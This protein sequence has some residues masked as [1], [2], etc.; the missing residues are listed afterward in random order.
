MSAATSGESTT[1]VGLSLSI[2]IYCSKS[3]VYFFSSKYKVSAS[4]T[5][6]FLAD[7]YRL[8][9]NATHP[10]LAVYQGQP[11]ASK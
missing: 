5:F 1:E 10:S 4:C 7:F 6:N 9:L 3:I 2:E 11:I 8:D